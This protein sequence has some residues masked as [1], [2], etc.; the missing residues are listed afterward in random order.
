MHRRSFSVK[1]SV[2]MILIVCLPLSIVSVQTFMNIRTITLQSNNELNQ[3]NLDSMSNNINI[4]FDQYLRITDLLF[5]SKEIQNLAKQKPENRIEIYQANQQFENAVSGITFNSAD[6]DNVYLF[7]AN[8]T[9]YFLQSNQNLSL[10]RDCCQEYLAAN[11]GLSTSNLFVSGF[12][13]EENK[14][15]PQYKIL[16]LR[17]LFNYVTRE[18]LG[19]LALE[20]SSNTL[21]KLLGYTSDITLVVSPENTILYNSYNSCMG[22]NITSFLGQPDSSGSY[23]NVRIDN[24][25]YSFSSVR[26]R[27]SWEIIYLADSYLSRQLIFSAVFPT[28]LAT[29]LCLTIFLVIAISMTNRMVLP[30]KQLEGL[31]KKVSEGDLSARASIHTGDE[32]ETLAESYNYMLDQL[33]QIIERACNAEG[34]RIDAEYRALQ[35]QINPHFLYNT[36]ETI[37]SLAQINNQS[38][39]SQMICSLADMFRY[40]THQS[41]KL[42]T[43]QEELTYL[44]NYMYIQ[45]FGYEDKIHITYD[46]PDNI[47][48]LRI[49]KVILQPLVE[50]CLHH[51]FEACAARY[52]I[53][54]RGHLINDI[55]EFTVTDDGIGMTKEQLEI[56]QKKL[57]AAQDSQPDKGSIGL[58]NIH[59]RLQFLFGADSGLSVTSA[60]GWGT[61]ILMKINLCEETGKQSHEKGKEKSNV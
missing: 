16:F 18:Y 15:Y 11:P 33:N 39:I 51:A 24:K 30:I 3:N 23:E 42:V 50:N 37:N 38:E 14:A 47:L 49:P 53:S 5:V 19:M 2:L 7:A 43:V 40:S 52:N 34:M 56:V 46:I 45:S 6:L 4:Y 27:Y 13:I 10:V 22:K 9:E 20:F 21:S 55:L 58:T 1:L 26:T 31:T 35:S 8:G 25:T 36:L 12:F 32:F 28:L 57:S 29:L 17:P 54:V 60:P 48:N 44:H 59:R 41:A 61:Q